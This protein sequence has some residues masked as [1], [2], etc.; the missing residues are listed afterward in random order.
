MPRCCACGSIMAWHS[1]MTSARDTGSRDIDSCPDSTFARS[2]ISLISFSRCHPA[3]RIWAMLSF[4]AGVAGG[5]SDSISWANPRMALS[6]L[7][8]SWLML[9]RNSDLAR[10]AFSATDRALSSSTFF[11]CSTWSSR[12][13]SV[14]SRAAAN[15]PLEILLL[16]FDL[17]ARGVAGAYQQIADDCGLSV[18]K[19]RDRHDCR[20]AAAV[21]ADVGQ[22]VDVLDPARSLEYQ[23][24]KAR[25]NRGSEFD[26]QRLGARDHFLWIGDVGRRD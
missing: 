20:K 11:S 15:T 18:A 4:W 21:L 25:R 19:R 26:A 17:L 10:F 23:C 8:N 16:C 1:S 3:R 7:R 24:L 22:F 6:G 14:M 12:L 13:P 9:E 5:E 2:R